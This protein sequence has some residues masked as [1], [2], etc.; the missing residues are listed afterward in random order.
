MYLKNGKKPQDRAAIE[1]T[2]VKVVTAI[3]TSLK[4]VK[5]N[6]FEELCKAIKE[7][8]EVFNSTP[9][10]FSQQSKTEEVSRN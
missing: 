3:I 7:R 1:D 9:C 6:S 10:H 2:V 4:N 8:F 5:F